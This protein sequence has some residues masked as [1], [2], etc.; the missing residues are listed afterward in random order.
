MFKLSA[1]I[2]WQTKV[3]GVTNRSVGHPHNEP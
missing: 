1:E 3:N 2:P